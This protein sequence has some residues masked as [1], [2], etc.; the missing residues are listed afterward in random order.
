LIYRNSFEYC[1]SVNFGAVWAALVESVIQPVIIH[2]LQKVCSVYA[3]DLVIMHADG[4][5]QVLEG[6]LNKDMA[7]A[8][9]YLQTWTLKLSTA[10][11]MSATLTTRKL[12][13]S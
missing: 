12:N 2:G 5:W 8:G 11:T 9:E 7:T 10:K 13:V 4:D 3:D 6:V 1:L